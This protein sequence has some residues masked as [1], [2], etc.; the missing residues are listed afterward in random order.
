MP[1]RECLVRALDDRLVDRDAHTLMLGEVERLK[2]FQRAVFIDR[3]NHPGH[4]VTLQPFIHTL[5]SSGRLRLKPIVMMP[6]AQDRTSHHVTRFRPAVS[7]L[8]RRSWQR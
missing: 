5:M 3:V 7:V 4:S 1:R 2:G 8:T 6:P